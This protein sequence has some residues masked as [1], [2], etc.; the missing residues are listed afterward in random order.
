MYPCKGAGFVTNTRMNNNLETN[1]THPSLRYRKLKHERA[2]VQYNTRHVHKGGVHRRR[3]LLH[4]VMLR[5]TSVFQ[6]HSPLLTQQI[7]RIL[8]VIPQR[9][10]RQ[11]NQIA[12]LHLL[13]MLRLTSIAQTH[14]RHL[15]V[16]H[17]QHAAQKRHL[18]L[19]VLLEQDVLQRT[20]TTPSISARQA[21]R[22]KELQ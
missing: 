4:V 9:R 6:T 1:V 5:V 2:R 15:R 21:C 16:H 22:G 8:H 3:P 20:V 10:E 17:V 7:D 19:R 14:L 13:L 12:L 11:I 18:L